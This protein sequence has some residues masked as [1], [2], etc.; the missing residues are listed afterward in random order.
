MA[1]LTAY[2]LIT[3][4]NLKTS[5]NFFLTHFQWASFSRQTGS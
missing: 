5:R 4:N 3:V 2:P 1:A